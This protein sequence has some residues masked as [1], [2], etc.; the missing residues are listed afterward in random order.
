MQAGDHLRASVVDGG[1]GERHPAGEV[2]LRF[3]EG[4]AVVLMPRESARLLGL[5]VDGLVPVE[6]HV[7]ADQVV[8]Q[9][10]E[11]RVPGERGGDRFALDEVDGE[12]D[13]SVSAMAMRPSSTL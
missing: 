4:V 3:D 5:L 8:A 2:L 13:G 6:A 10:G 7:G 12:R 11:H 1:I 9:I